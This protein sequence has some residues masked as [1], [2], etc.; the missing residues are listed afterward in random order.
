MI[1][2]AD[3]RS[4]RNQAIKNLAKVRAQQTGKRFKMVRLDN[5]TWVEREVK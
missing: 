2:T 3:K 5:R 4:A 1:K